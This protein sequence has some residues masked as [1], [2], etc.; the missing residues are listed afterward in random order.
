MAEGVVNSIPKKGVSRAVWTGLEAG[1]TGD[2][3]Y[4]YRDRIVV[5]ATGTFDSETVTINGSIDGTNF[6]PL[7]SDG[8]TAVAFT[9]DGMMTVYEAVSYIQPV[10]SDA[11]GTVDVDIVA[12]GIVFGHGA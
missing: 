8:T 1:D 12:E 5:Q 6:F 11:G 10:I 3:G 9:V 7:T 2:N 4:C